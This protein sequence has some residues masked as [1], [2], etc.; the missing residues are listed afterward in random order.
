MNP[1]AVDEYNSA[2]LTQ[3]VDASGAYN[4]FVALHSTTRTGSGTTDAPYRH[5]V[6]TFVAADATDGRTVA[7]HVRDQSEG[8]KGYSTPLEDDAVGDD[9]SAGFRVWTVPSGSVESTTPMTT[10][11]ATANAGAIASF[12]F[13][14]DETDYDLTDMVELTAEVVGYSRDAKAAMVIGDDDD[15]DDRDA[16]DYPDLAAVSA[17]PFASPFKRVDFYAESEDGAEL[18][19]IA[20]VSSPT[21]LKR[22]DIDGDDDG[23][24][25]VEDAPAPTD[26]ITVVPDGNDDDTSGAQNAGEER[27]RRGCQ[28]HVILWGHG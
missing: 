3:S 22:E 13:A 21:G 17:I 18:R 26:R 27:R 28:D 6:A 8:N 14:P 15:A 10:T 19:F 20:S 16:A 12:T 25:D 23:V 4:A 11:G 2:G 24:D 5:G 9:L 7:I 1:V